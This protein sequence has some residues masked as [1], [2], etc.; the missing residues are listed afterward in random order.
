MH[1]GIRGPLYS[2]DDLKNDA[3]FGFKIIHCDEFQTEGIDKIVKRIRDRVGNNP[4]YLSIDIDV[5]MWIVD[6]N[7]IL[8]YADMSDI[9]INEDMSACINIFF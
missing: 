5:Y 6:V 1:V 3:E 4:L 9:N 8:Y 7:G 2:R